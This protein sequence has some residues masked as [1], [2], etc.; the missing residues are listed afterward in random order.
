MRKGP[1]MGGRE[2]QGVRCRLQAFGGDASALRV[3]RF[4]SRT[5]APGEVRVGMLFAPVNPADLNVIHGTYGELPE[6]PT[7]IGNEGCGVV[8]DAGEGAGFHEGDMVMPLCG[9]TWTSEMVVSAEALVR[10][11][12]GIAPVQA[13]MLG[14]TP[15]TAWLMLHGFRSLA[16]GDWVVQNAAN[17][18]VGRA[19]IGFARQLGLRTLN[20]VR[21][22]ELVE[23]LL[24]LGADV[25]VTEELDLRAGVETLCG[26]KRPALALNAVGGASALNLANALADGGVHV[27]YGGM[28]RQPLK[29][30]NGLLI[31]RGLEFRGFWLRRWRESAPLPEVRALYEKLAGLLRTGVFST[32]VGRIYPLA[33][34]ADAVAAAASGG[35][36]GKVMLDLSC[37]GSVADGRIAP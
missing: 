7:T 12:D 22:E 35:V 8:L 10:L 5:L 23:E 11:P 33:E 4:P 24:G 36:G 32:P 29:V 31:F 17:S 37:A 14:V 13:A 28:G 18:G 30:P 21:R 27:T 34:V 20:V 19:V 16:S 15:A 25:V 9:G 2:L 26:G 1:G 3:E 6:L